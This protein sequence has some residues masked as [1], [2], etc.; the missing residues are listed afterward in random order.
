MSKMLVIGRGRTSLAEDRLQRADLN[1][2]VSGT[3]RLLNDVCWFVCSVSKFDY[4]LLG[5][6]QTP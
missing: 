2:G 1:V 3:P 6:L 4:E 5:V